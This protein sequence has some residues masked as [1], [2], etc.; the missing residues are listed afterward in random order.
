MT[1]TQATALKQL[2]CS[3]FLTCSVESPEYKGNS[4]SP[5]ASIHNEW[6]VNLMYATVASCFVCRRTYLGLV[7]GHNEAIFLTDFA[8]VGAMKH[9]NSSHFSTVAAKFL[10]GNSG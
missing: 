9:L 5:G 4:C 2:A 6:L 1:S 8:Y 7:Q 10:L 3:L